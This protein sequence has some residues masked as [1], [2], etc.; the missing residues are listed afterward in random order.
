MRGEFLVIGRPNCRYCTLARELLN[1]QGFTHEYT[2]LGDHLWLR[3]LIRAGGFRT[4]PII[5]A[6]PFTADVKLIGGYRQLVEYI[7]QEKQGT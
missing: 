7:E 6:D 1:S 4:I 3:E 2:D 5:L